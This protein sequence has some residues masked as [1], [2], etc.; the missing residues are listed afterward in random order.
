MC[1]HM[2]TAM[3]GTPDIHA[4]RR[5][6]LLLR[7]CA[8]ICATMACYLARDVQQDLS[9]LR[10]GVQGICLDARISSGERRK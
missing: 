10:P 3:L 8:T 2:V 4:R 5:Q 6:I 1:E 9:E 7:D